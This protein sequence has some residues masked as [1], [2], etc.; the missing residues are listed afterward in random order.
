MVCLSKILPTRSSLLRTVAVATDRSFRACCGPRRLVSVP[1]GIFNRTPS[2]EPNRDRDFGIGVFS[3]N[4]AICAGG[5][6]HCD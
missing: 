3:V 4:V 6:W 2:F 5:L 1:R